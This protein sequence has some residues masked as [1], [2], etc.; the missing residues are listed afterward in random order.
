MR[1]EIDLEQL[2][3]LPTW[4]YVVAAATATY[5]VAGKLLKKYVAAQDYIS[6]DDRAMLTIAWL[7]APL[8]PP[9]LALWVALWPLSLGFIP[10]PWRKSVW[11]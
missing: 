7:A 11:T 3:R 5:M 1:V 6:R 10:P 9:F 4:M 8:W 2:A